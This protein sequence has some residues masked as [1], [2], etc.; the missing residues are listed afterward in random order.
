M[1]CMVYTDLYSIDGVHV[2][3][4]QFILGAVGEQL[5]GRFLLL[6]DDLGSA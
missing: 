1:A 3:R 2:G 5:I 4:E 6:A